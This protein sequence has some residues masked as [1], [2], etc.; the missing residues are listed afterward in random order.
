MHNYIFVKDSI[1]IY[2]SY[3]LYHIYHTCYG[4]LLG[5]QNVSKI[6]SALPRAK[7]IFLNR[8]TKKRKLR[9]EISFANDFLGLH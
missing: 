4:K 8:V 1:A 7:I 6:W 2:G 3:R 5:H 9:F